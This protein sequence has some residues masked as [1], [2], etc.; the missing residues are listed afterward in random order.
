MLELGNSTPLIVMADANLDAAATAIVSNGYLFSGQACISI[1][2]VLVERAAYPALVD[3][4]VP[5]IA[6]LRTG[7]PLDLATQIGPVISQAS[8]NRILEWV[9]LAE[10]AGATLLTGEVQVEE[11]VLRPMLLGNV[12]DS[13]AVSS[14]KI[15][16][17]VVTIEMVTNL[18]ESVQ[19]ANNT[20]YGLQAGIFTADFAS[21]LGAVAELDFGGVT[22]NESP[23]FRSDHMPYG[24]NKDSG[25]T[26]EGPAYVVHE[27]SQYRT[28]NL[29]LYELT[30]AQYPAMQGVSG[31]QTDRS[32][33]M[34][35]PRRASVSRAIYAV[36]SAPAA[37]SCW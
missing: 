5:A 34:L 30:G 2:R 11:L 29:P 31:W 14:K 7:D 15:F 13:M 23:S 4:L 21:A 37:P 28:V 36:T 33:S 8:C 24:G 25:N 18:K 3:K 17:P 6:R 9:L 27:F 10:R 12:D 16:G 1:Q 26:R 19:K 22:I 35:G 20:H 32:L